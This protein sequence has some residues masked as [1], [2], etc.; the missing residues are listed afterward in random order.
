MAPLPPLAAGGG[1]ASGLRP[2]SPAWLPYGDAM[3]VLGV[4]A[5]IVIHTCDMI[6]FSPAAG[7]RHWWVINFVDA[8]GRWAV[9][10]FI[11]LSGALLLNPSRPQTAMEFYRRRLARLGIATLFWSA[12]FM[13]L[14]VYYT[15]WCV[16]TWD[17]PVGEGSWK[18]SIWKNLLKG[19]PYMHLHFVFRL[20]GL[21]LLTPM[22]RVYVRNAPWG[23]R[24][25]MMLAV[26]AM[27]MAN[28]IATPFLGTEPSGFAILWPFLGFYLAGDV[29]RDVQPTGRKAALSAAGLVLCTAV[30][31]IETG[32]LT[33]A[34]QKPDPYPAMDMLMYDFL[35]P[36]RVLSAFCAWFLLAW[37]FTRV[38][39]RSRTQRAMKALAPLTLG[40]YL[41]HPLFREVLWRDGYRLFQAAV[42]AEENWQVAGMLWYRPEWWI[43]M[44]LMMLAILAGS[45]ALTWLLRLV[46]GVRKITG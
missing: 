20:A 21:Y 39:P 35:N 40:I 17:S 46:P 37:W 31:A 12:F 23:L 41:V 4:A 27:A 30:I 42:P 36:A 11:M 25:W 32:R 28:S 15:G 43:G 29:L 14:A 22:L 10:V 8:G 33:V 18:S 26:L 38:P 19:Q 45:V 3:R 34:G 2:G 9:P 16:G 7:T 1:G 24:A 13:A 44:P 6:L 5:I